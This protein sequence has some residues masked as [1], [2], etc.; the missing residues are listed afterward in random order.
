[1]LGKKL[2][3]M[4]PGVV[5]TFVIFFLIGVWHVANWNAV[6]YGS[7]FGIM[8][9]AA[10]MLEPLFKKLR[11]LLH[12]NAKAW[13]WKAIGLVRT[14][15]LVLLAQYF[16]F[17]AGPKEGFALLVGTFR[18]WVFTGAGERFTAMMAP[19]EWNI[20]V[21]ALVIIFVVDLLCEFGVDV[22]GK[23]SKGTLLIRWPV[24]IGLILA[25]LVFGCYGAGFD[26]SAFLYT[27]F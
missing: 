18:N 22:N 5:A 14:L 23:L 2:G 8:L 7:Y 4:V 16:A 27:Q 24:L 3:R 13:W 21:A 26:A 25:I 10:L 6:I 11:T 19:L 9:G 1:M 17:T 12:I 15:A 20:A